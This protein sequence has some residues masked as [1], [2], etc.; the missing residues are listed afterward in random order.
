MQSENLV[1]TTYGTWSLQV[2]GMI[3][4]LQGGALLGCTAHATASFSEREAQLHGEKQTTQQ[5][6]DA[7]P[8]PQTQVAKNVKPAPEQGSSDTEK[9]VVEALTTQEFA[10]PQNPEKKALKAALTCG[11][12]VLKK[13]GKATCYAPVRMW[14]ED[15]EITC[16]RA[17]AIFGDTGALRQLH[18]EGE[19]RIVTADHLGFAKKAIYDEKSQKITLEDEARLKQKGMQLQGKKV[20]M[21]LVS[22]EVSVEGG[23]QGL[24]T[25]GKQAQPKK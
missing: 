7:K 9:E 19:V 20:V 13:G 15:V 11:K 1:Q 3:G 22:E 17:Q 2:W 10:A 25:P 8:V 24:Y 5:H 4:V 6:Y 23:V 16:E 14:R 21:D 18:C 12:M